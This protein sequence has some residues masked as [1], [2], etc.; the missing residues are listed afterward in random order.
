MRLDEYM[1]RATAKLARADIATARLDCL[2]LIEDALQRDRSWLLAH[3]DYVVD[4]AVTR[5]LDEQIA[6]RAEHEPLAY[7]RGKS[8]FY[9]REFIVNPH[10]LE[11]RPETETMI[12]LLKQLVI[13]RQSSVAS[14]KEETQE[15]PTSSHGPATRD[16]RQVTSDNNLTI[17][18]VGTGSGCIAITTKLIYPDASVIATD[19]DDKCLKLARQ[20]AK[21]HDTDITFLK[22]DLLKPFTD[23]HVGSTYVESEADFFLSNGVNRIHHTMHEQRKEKSDSGPQANNRVVSST[24]KQ[25]VGDTWILLANLPYVPDGHT[26]NAAAMFEPKH[27]LFGGED[28]LDYYRRLFSQAAQLS[29]PPSS[30]FTESLPSQHDTLTQIAHSRGYAPAITDDFII[31]FDRT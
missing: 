31:R 25:V 5:A 4:G 2:V 13:S 8:E 9:G 6:R 19:I 3:P 26:I 22:G 21:T 18:D 12:D 11:P 29:T 7:I 30:I 17:I 14:Q 28:G 27:A 16:R 10:T 20:N 15:I 23:L 1:R 24:D